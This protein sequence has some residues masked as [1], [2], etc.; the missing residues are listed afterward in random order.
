MK[1]VDFF[2]KEMTIFEV[3]TQGKFSNN[4]GKNIC[5]FFH[6]LTEFPFPKS[7]SELDHYHQMMNTRIPLSFAEQLNT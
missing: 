6:V 4:H 2:Y 3:A 7:E 1:R 5:R